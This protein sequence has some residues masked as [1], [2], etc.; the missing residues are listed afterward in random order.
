MGRTILLP[1]DEATPADLLDLATQFAAHD[2]NDGSAAAVVGSLIRAYEL[3]FEMDTNE[4]RSPV[5]KF[6]TARDAEVAYQ[7]AFEDEYGADNTESAMWPDS[8]PFVSGLPKKLV[9]RVA[10]EVAARDRA[11]LQGFQRHIKEKSA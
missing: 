9:L 7:R 2:E 1:V 6:K 11:S 3:S 5:S 10:R 4:N 8:L